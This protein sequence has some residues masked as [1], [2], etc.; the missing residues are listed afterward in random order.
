M[1]EEKLASEILTQLRDLNGNLAAIHGAIV[2]LQKA[3][4]F[5]TVCQHHGNERADAEILM[6]AVERWHSR[7]TQEPF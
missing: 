7:L 6:P 4:V 1:D 5:D 3:Q 2:D